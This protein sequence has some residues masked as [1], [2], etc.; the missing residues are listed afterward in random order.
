MKITA[1]VARTPGA[2]FSIEEI[3][4]EAPGEREVRVRIV[5]AGVCHTDLIARDQA[6]PVPLPAVLGHEGSG[7][8]EAVGSAVT[9]L[10]EGDPVVLSFMSCGRCPRCGGG[11]PSYCHAFVPLNFAG[12]RPDGSSPLSKGEERISGF[13]FGQS[14][15]ASHAIAHQRN[16]VKL[17][18]DVPEA[19]LRLLGPL[20]CGF[21]TGAGSVMR[22]LACKPGSSIVI[23]GGGAVGQAAVMG[24]AV[25]GCKLIVLVE[26]HIGRRELA[27]GIGATHA[28]DPGQGK[29]V[30]S[31][32]A[33]LPDGADYALDNTGMAQV[34]ESALVCLAPHGTLGLVAAATPDTA[35]LLNFTSLVLSGH[36]IKG[37]L[38]G[39]S[40]PHSF[41][42][43]LVGLHRQGRL[44]LEKLVRTFPLHEINE[45]IAAQHRGEC[46]KAVLLP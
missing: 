10:R 35:I 44:P 18:G 16:V 14:S 45:A 19:Q 36:S 6:I 26:P 17:D 30:D 33:I 13:F 15:F 38:E 20:G 9:R 7:I 12:A 25:Q 39:D 28:I 43:E 2:D 37:I 40:D 32:R 27:L 24:A 41:I 1:A 11:E 34:V 46:V 23:Y 8:V 22:S 31:I 5:G 21:Q 42:P 29:V 3:E 4:L